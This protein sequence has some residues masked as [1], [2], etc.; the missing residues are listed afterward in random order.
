M[1]QVTAPRHALGLQREFG[2]RGSL[3]PALNETIQPVVIVADTREPQPYGND[4]QARASVG[5]TVN[6]GA[7]RAHLAISIPLIGQN[8]KLISCTVSALGPVRLRFGH[9]TNVLPAPVPLG[10]G[11][12]VNYNRLGPPSAF[13]V[14]DI[15]TNADLV[16][17]PFEG[18]ITIGGVDPFRIE[19]NNV[20]TALDAVTQGAQSWCIEN[21]ING[22]GNLAWSASLVWDEFPGTA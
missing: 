2:V 14:S 21:A 11:R 9:R 20:L 3:A 7:V 13:L 17:A 8:A 5:I 10:T 1:Q 15:T 19:L 18:D 22:P 12:W 6:P 4:Y 16:D